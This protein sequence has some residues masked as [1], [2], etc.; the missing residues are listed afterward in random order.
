MKNFLGLLETP[1]EAA[2]DPLAAAD[3]LLAV[4]RLVNE[5]EPK[6]PMTPA[7]FLVVLPIPEENPEFFSDI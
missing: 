6:R 4:R 3:A 1:A 7:E 5:V 2:E